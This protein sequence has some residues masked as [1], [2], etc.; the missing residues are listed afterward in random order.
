MFKFIVNWFK[1]PATESLA[2]AVAPEAA[3]YKVEASVQVTP[4]VEAIPVAE[5]K[6]PAPKKPAAKKPA[7]AKKPAA[8][9]AAKKPAAITAKPAKKNK[10]S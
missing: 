4:V 9:S 8:K 3:P 5:T 1:K 6:K 7:P 2:P 10:G